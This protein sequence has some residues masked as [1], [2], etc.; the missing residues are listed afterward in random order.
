MLKVSISNELKRFGC[1][2]GGWSVGWFNLYG[3]RVL[4]LTRELASSPERGPGRCF[5]AAPTSLNLHYESER[6]MSFAGQ[7]RLHCPSIHPVQSSP[8]MPIVC[9]MYVAMWWCIVKR[10]KLR[11]LLLLGGRFG[12]L[13]ILVDYFWVKFL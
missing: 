8:S 13:Y 5:N 6:L 12:R 2:E 7:L 10:R 3:C 4:D 11:R 9:S 1:M